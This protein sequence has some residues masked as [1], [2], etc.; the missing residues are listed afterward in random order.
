MHIASSATATAKGSPK[1]ASTDKPRVLIVGAGM[2]GLMLGALLEKSNVPYEIFERATSIKPLDKS[3]SG[4]GFYIVAR[5]KLYNLIFKQVPANKIYLGQRVLNISEKED[6]VFVHLS[7]NSI[8]DGDIVVGADGAY[9][10][11]RQRIFEQLL[12]K[13]ELPKSDQE[14]LPFSCTCLIGQT[15]PLDPEQYP[16]V[17]LP[18]SSFCS[19]IGDKKSY[20]WHLFTTSQNTIAYMVV[21]YLDSKSSKTALDQRFRQTENSD[22]ELTQHNGCVMLEEKVFQT[23]YSGRYVLLGDGAFTKHYNPCHKLHPAGGLG[24]VAA[25]HDAIA[26]ANLLYAMPGS[27]TKEITVLFREYYTERHPAVTEAFNYSHR[28]SKISS[29]GILGAILAKTIRFRPQAG[30]LEPI[31]IMGTIPPVPSSNELKARAVFEKQ[32][33]VA[34][35]I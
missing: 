34:N 23:W 19:Y 26:L 27:T 12:A 32:K 6:K 14:A 13:G 28:A 20:S 1:I 17:K 10:A 7:D 15:K 30:F 22:G 33:H 9:S 8:H 35:A 21:H 5:P 16:I 31:D 3:F 4:Y 18:E 29:A 11:I 2:G 25:M 24:A